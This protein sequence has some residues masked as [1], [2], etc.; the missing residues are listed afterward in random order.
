MATPT[1]MTTPLTWTGWNGEAQQATGT[2]TTGSVVDGRNTMLGRFAF[3][4]LRIPSR[5]SRAILAGLI[6]G[7]G[8]GSAVVYTHTRVQGTTDVQAYGGAR[9]V[10]TI[11]DISRN[12]AASDISNLNFQLVNPIPGFSGTTVSAAYPTDTSGNGGGNKVG[13]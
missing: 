5:T 6:S 13:V 9:V 3:R 7:G 4:L 1:R 10:E 2:G 12:I 11:T 8:V